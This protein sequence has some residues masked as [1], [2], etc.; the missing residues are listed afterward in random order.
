MALQACGS[1]EQ[2]GALKMLSD[3]RD[4]EFAECAF[5]PRNCDW[6]DVTSL[7]GGLAVQQGFLPV[8]ALGNS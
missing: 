8:F 2:R 5:F 6:P 7:L 1:E 4:S 3:L